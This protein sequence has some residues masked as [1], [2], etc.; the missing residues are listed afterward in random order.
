MGAF[1]REPFSVQQKEAQGISCKHA[2]RCRVDTEESCGLNIFFSR[3]D[4]TLKTSRWVQKQELAPVVVTGN[5]SRDFV[6]ELLSLKS[7][8]LK[9][10]VMHRC[11]GCCYDMFIPPFLHKAQE[12]VGPTLRDAVRDWPDGIQAGGP[13]PSACS[14]SRVKL[15]NVNLGGSFK[16]Q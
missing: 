7:I 14:P 13:H 1:R 9:L 10:D 11:A 12:H 4:L 3:N 16:S 5:T 15:S 2:Q 8:S 6:S